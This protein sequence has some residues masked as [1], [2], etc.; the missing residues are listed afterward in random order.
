MEGP[1]VKGPMP[2]WHRFDAFLA[3]D[4][5]AALLDWALASRERFA[6]A[7]VYV[8]GFDP[9]VRVAGTLGDLGPLKAVFHRRLRALAP[10]M[11]RRA[12]SPP[13]EVE[14]F[15]LEMA[16]H[17]DGAFYA[18]HSDLPLGE[19]RAADPDGR[20]RRHRV[21]S[22]V[23]YFHREPRLFSGGALRL[24]RF[25]GEDIAGDFVDIDPRQNSLVVFPSWAIHEVRRVELASEDFADSR[26]A[27]NIWL[28]RTLAAA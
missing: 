21:V 25:G 5:H 16:A 17:G 24:F 9:L 7:K 27:V 11:I 26:F 1:A 20:G 10:E 19:A 28:H 8:K 23:Y 13:F 3:P 14:K 15:E 2:P 22:A 4:E 6:P 18:R 12:G